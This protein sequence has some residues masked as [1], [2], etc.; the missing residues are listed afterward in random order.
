MT[1][2]R[3]TFPT[4]NVTSKGVVPVVDGSVMIATVDKIGVDVKAYLNS[5]ATELEAATAGD[6]LGVTA[7]GI[8]ANKLN[9]ALTELQSN[10]VSAATGDI[11]NSSI[12]ELKM[13]DDMKKQAGGVAEF[14]TVDGLEASLLSLS[15]DVGSLD[16]EIDILRTSKDSTGATNAYI[17]DTP[18]TFDFVDGNLVHFNPNFTN[19]GSATINIDGTT[20][21]IKKFDIDADVYVNLEAED[22]KK[23]NTVQLRYDISEAA[24]CLAPKTGGS[25][26]LK[27][28]RMMDTALNMNGKNAVYDI[29]IPSAI[30]DMDYAFIKVRWSWFGDI[31]PRINKPMFEITS[32]TNVQLTTTQPAISNEYIRYYIEVVEL[33]P[34]MYKPV[35]KIKEYSQYSTMPN[36][37]D[38][39]KT[40]LYYTGLGSS[41]SAQYYFE[42]AYLFSS[43]Q[44]KQEGY[45]VGAMKTYYVVES[46]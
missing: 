35:Q 43:T 37:V 23:F 9:A 2:T 15:E 14:D 27:V 39:S 20:V 4:D 41:G 24:F 13:T 16:E 25:P 22:I 10:I 6:D 17:L 11:P 8:V 36:A 30:T 32:A 19:T 38:M 5:L 3:P 26:I 44:I 46:K 40:M 45:N 12:S 33:N 42:D 7:V 29:S 21:N 18:A 34:T 31:D 1:I 28:Q